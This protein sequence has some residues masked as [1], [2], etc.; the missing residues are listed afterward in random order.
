MIDGL[1]RPPAVLAY[2]GVGPADS[3]DARVLITLD[4]L[5]SQI[6]Y[7]KRRGYRFAT[8]E[9]ILEEGAPGNGTAVLTFDDGLASAAG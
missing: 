2:H 1:L 7:L 9:G 8:A 6:R 5:E 3:D 4:R